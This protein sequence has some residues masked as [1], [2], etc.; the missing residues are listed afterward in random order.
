VIIIINNNY[1]G[2]LEENN[3]SILESTASEPMEQS[4][5]I[6]I[7]SNENSELMSP[8]PSGE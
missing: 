4:G 6:S 1:K 3:V 5:D 8:T 7:T 2:L